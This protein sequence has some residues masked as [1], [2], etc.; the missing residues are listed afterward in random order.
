MS[1]SALPNRSRRAA[2]LRMDDGPSPHRPTTRGTAYAIIGRRIIHH[3]VGG[4]GIHVCTFG[5]RRRVGGRVVQ[6]L[7][8]RGQPLPKTRA[9]EAVVAHFDK[10]FGQ[11][12]L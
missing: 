10:T 8:Q 1:S 5:E 2:P 12:V 6:L 3:V 4:L 9:E 7:A 11:D